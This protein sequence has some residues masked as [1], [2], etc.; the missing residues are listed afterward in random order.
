MDIS[1]KIP[2]MTMELQKKTR[3]IPN[4]K[5]TISAPIF[6]ANL[7]RFFLVGIPTGYSMYVIPAI[8]V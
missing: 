8:S 5:W 4:K 1:A 3:N 2:M 7:N 6:S